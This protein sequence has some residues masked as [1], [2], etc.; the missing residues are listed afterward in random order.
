[1]TV[2]RGVGEVFDIIMLCFAR[3]GVGGEAW[4]S[5]YMAVYV[6]NKPINHG[7][8]VGR[9]INTITIQSQRL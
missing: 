7:Q 1:M 2:V 8:H 3:G 9:S 6:Y 4:P 5:R